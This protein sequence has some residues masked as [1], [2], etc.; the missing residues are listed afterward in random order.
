MAITLNNVELVE[1]LGWGI[2]TPC[3]NWLR[4]T[5]VYHG[6]AANLGSDYVILFV[7]VTS[8]QY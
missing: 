5:A 6:R 8:R 4:Q 7:E 2:T 3:K 1:R